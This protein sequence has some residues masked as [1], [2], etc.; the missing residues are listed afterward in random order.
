MTAFSGVLGIFGEIAFSVILPLFA[1][2]TI[3]AWALYGAKSAQYL[4]SKNTKVTKF[5][6]D[7]IYIL[8]I[9]GISLLTFFFGDNLGAD[10]VWL[11]SDMT[12]ALMAL[13]NLIALIILSG[14][15]VKVTKNYFDRK[16]GKDV[17]EMISAYED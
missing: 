2:T 15:L 9:V 4:F 3:L 16:S 8:M 5:V 7:I 1:F 6:F 17:P 10:F 12:N 14:T 13:P 11:I